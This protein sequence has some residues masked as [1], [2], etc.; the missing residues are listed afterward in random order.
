MG[1]TYAACLGAIALSGSIVSGLLANSSP[2]SILIQSITVLF[3][4]AG[5]GWF[6]GQAADQAVRHSVEMDFRRRV[7]QM[8]NKE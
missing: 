4:F 6:V 7:E 2:D 5:L 1:R 8:K 3:P